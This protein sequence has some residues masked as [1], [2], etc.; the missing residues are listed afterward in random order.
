MG[1]KQRAGQEAGPFV[2]DF[3]VLFNKKSEEIP[4]LE[5]EAMEMLKLWESGDKEVRA[6]W[7]KMNNW[8]Y[9]GFDETYE[10]LGIKFD[11]T[12][13]ESDYYEKGKK[14]AEDAYEKGLLK[15]NA[16]RNIC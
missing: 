6:L 1:R 9:K 5:N 7:K 16:E 10:K 15:K 2:G 4:E 13:Y 14:I 8:V 3:Y 12:Y 11:V